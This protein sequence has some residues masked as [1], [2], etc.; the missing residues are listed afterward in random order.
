MTRHTISTCLI[1]AAFLLLA[2]GNA[3]AISTDIQVF[4]AGGP[5]PNI[6]FLMDSSGSMGSSPDS[7]PA[8]ADKWTLA[9]QA[10]ADMVA[11]FG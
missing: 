1:T 6:L 3:S 11:A 10:V 7:C 8:C 9:R 5:A 2:S 4:S